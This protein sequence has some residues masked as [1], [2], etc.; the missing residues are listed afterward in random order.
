MNSEL[1]VFDSMKIL[2]TH[3]TTE[4][5]NK[6][7]KSFST[8]EV[9]IQSG[10]NTIKSKKGEQILSS[11]KFKQ[12]TEKKSTERKSYDHETNGNNLDDSSQRGTDR[13]STSCKIP[14]ILSHIPT[15]Q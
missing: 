1:E 3:S 7:D 15:P 12:E 4:N 10:K 6:A 13:L 11:S 9:Q 2:K 8:E 14:K 5:T